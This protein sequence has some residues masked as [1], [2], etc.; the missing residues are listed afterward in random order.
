MLEPITAAVHVVCKCV[1]ERAAEITGPNV[2]KQLGIRRYSSQVGSLD[3]I[4]RSNVHGV[5]H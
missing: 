5:A 2:L 4:A 1:D 3:F